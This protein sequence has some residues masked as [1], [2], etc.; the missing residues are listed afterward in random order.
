[1]SM[2][3]S[4]AHPSAAGRR[5]AP[6]RAGLTKVRPPRGRSWVDQSRKPEQANDRMDGILPT[7]WEAEG[8]P[9]GPGVHHDA[10]PSWLPL[11][12]SNGCKILPAPLAARPQGEEE[13]EP[14][15][16]V[17][18]NIPRKVPTPCSQGTRPPPTPTGF[19]WFLLRPRSPLLPR[20]SSAIHRGSPGSHGPSLFLK[21]VLG[22]SATWCSPPAHPAAAPW[23]PSFTRDTVGRFCR[24]AGSQA[25]GA[26]DVLSP[27]PPAHGFGSTP[28]AADTA[29]KV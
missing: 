25:S 7:A 9:R 12:G 24:G 22:A 8:G 13:R 5:Q 23:R 1:M 19:S 17:A 28:A 6:N 18:F 2:D 26:C 3:S 11:L 16:S 4:R 21:Y 10:V 14:R 27:W 29:H 20:R 15:P